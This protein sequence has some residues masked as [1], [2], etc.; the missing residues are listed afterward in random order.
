MFVYTTF[1]NIVERPEG[2]KIASIFIVSIVI[3]SLV[4]RVLRS[5]ELRIQAVEPDER[6]RSFIREL[7]SAPMAIIANR[8]DLGGRGGVRAQAA[9]GA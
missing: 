7:A 5:T 6:A 4:S 9:R 2:I 1:V 8:P 3:T